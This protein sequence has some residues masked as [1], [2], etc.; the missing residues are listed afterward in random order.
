MTDVARFEQGSKLAEHFVDRLAGLDHHQDSARLLEGAH[1]FGERLGAHDVARGVVGDELVGRGL[2]EVP[3]GDRKAV[4]VDVEPPGCGP[5]PRAR[6][7][8]N[9]LLRWCS[10][11]FFSSKL[12]AALPP[13]GLGRQER[14]ELGD[15]P[16]FVVPA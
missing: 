3:H 16:R 10:S 4:V 15:D 5:S 13:G 1:E 11:S 2:L 9:Q 12:G 14:H 6:S 7:P 8:R